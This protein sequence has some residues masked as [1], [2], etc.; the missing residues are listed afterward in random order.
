M[1]AT[2]LAEA[3]IASTLLM[4]LVLLA[5]GPVRRAFGARVGYALW[6]LPGLRLALP[7]LPTWP[8]AASPVTLGRETIVVLVAAP[9]AIDPSFPAASVALAV[10]AIGA[11][12]LLLRHLVRHHR[13]CRTILAGAAIAGE[14]DGIRVVASD[15]AA[16]PMAFGIRRRTIAV[17]RDFAERYDPAERALALAH[18]AAH[19]HRG[20]LIANWAALFVLAC[21]WWN[22]LAWHAWQAFRSDQELANDAHVLAHSDPA[23]RHAYGCAILKTAAGPAPRSTCHLHSIRNLKGRLSMLTLSPASPRRLVVGRAAVSLLVASGLVATASGTRASAAVAD[24]LAASGVA[25]SRV[26]QSTPPAPP[27]PVSA[28]KGVKRVVVVR[29]GRTTTYQGA[30]ANA[31]VAANP[32]PVPPV[33]PVPPLPVRAPLPPMVADGRTIF[34]PRPDVPRIVSRACATAGDGRAVVRDEDEGGQ[35]RI[36]ICTDRI[37]AMA[38]RGA[39]IAA[40]AKSIERNALTAALSGLRAARSGV[41][42]G[43][44]AASRRALPAIDAAIAEVEADLAGVN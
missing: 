27:A 16:G 43:D 7:P 20:D 30:A 15:G 5:R 24:G 22:P 38:A 31:Y 2:W 40:S 33:P 9:E 13:F 14:A 23:L 28:A 42:A 26:A 10:W 1:T 41:L 37:A 36:V 17:P 44:A 6:A 21:H 11:G 3:L 19:H 4:A 25:L 29:D 39:A 12:G 32:P 34:V 35:R 8:V 18:E